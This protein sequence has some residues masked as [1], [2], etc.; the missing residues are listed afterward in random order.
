MTPY[1][2]STNFVRQGGG[3]GVRTGYM[4]D[5]NAQGAMG[6]IRAWSGDGKVYRTEAAAQRAGASYARRVS[7]ALRR[8][9]ARSTR[10][11]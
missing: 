5:L 11:T 7:S 2:V 9:L 1:I 8:D 6:L 3:A 4:F 10:G